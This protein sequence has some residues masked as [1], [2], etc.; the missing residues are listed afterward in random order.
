[1]NYMTT[2]NSVELEYGY[3]RPSKSSILKMVRSFADVRHYR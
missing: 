1:M 2:S 3:Q